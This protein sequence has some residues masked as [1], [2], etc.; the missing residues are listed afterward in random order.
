MREGRRPQDPGTEHL[1]HE[2]AAGGDDDVEVAATLPDD[3]VAD[4]E[5]LRAE[6]PQIH[7]HARPDVPAHRVGQAQQSRPGAAV[8]GHGHS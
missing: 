1:V 6:V 8:S 7:P 2:Q 4:A 5:Q 3:L